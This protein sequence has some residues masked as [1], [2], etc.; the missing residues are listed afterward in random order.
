[1][2]D[3]YQA[4][5]PEIQIFD[6]AE[7]KI[8]LWKALRRLPEDQQMVIQLHYIFQLPVKTIAIQMNCSVTA[9]YA[10][11]YRGLYTLKKEFSPKLFEKANRILYDDIPNR[12]SY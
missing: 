10:K 4:I 2:K 7:K 1:M 12:I 11:L 3:I 6:L 9:T 8:A 5:S